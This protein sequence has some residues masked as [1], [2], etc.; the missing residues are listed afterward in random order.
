M[1]VWQAHSNPLT[2]VPS[3]PYPTAPH[4]IPLSALGSGT[5]LRCAL[6]RYTHTYHNVLCISS[7]HSFLFRYSTM[8]YIAPFLTRHSWCTLYRYVKMCCVSHDTTHFFPDTLS[9][10]LLHPWHT[11]QSPHA[12]HPW[13]TYHPRHT[14]HFGLTEHPWQTYHPR[15]TDYFGLT[16]HPWQTYHPRHTDHFGLTDHPWQTSHIWHTQHPPRTEHPWTY[17]VPLTNISHLTYR[18]S[19]LTINP[20][21]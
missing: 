2:P 11:Q 5:K 7:H 14:D 12:E 8:A 3:F 20:S 16:E 1:H 19:F 21:P 9:L 13:R 10:H 17:R 18:A 15:H 4:S 6:P